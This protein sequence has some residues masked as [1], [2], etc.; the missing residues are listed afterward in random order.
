M[1]QWAAPPW[2]ESSV[3]NASCLPQFP[4]SAGRCV[5]CFA[6]CPASP[7]ISAGHCKV[8]F[9]GVLFSSGCCALSCHW[10][11]FLLAV[12]F[13]NVVIQN[14]NHGH[15]GY[16]GSILQAYRAAPSR[17]PTIMIFLLWFSLLLFFF[18]TL[19]KCFLT[20]LFLQFCNFNFNYSNF[21]YNIC[22]FNFLPP[23][24]PLYS[25]LLSFAF[26]ARRLSSS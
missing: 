9:G 1:P 24:P 16:S 20:L 2:V 7:A 25:S 18:C 12:D 3:R 22:P 14:K 8:L 4:Q 15:L 19:M 6:L 26:M 5:P 11:L 17:L 10:L 13:I 21:N 23:N